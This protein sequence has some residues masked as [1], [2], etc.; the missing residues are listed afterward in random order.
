VTA[1]D[2]PLAIKEAVA[3]SLILKIPDICKLISKLLSF[4]DLAIH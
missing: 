1:G 4:T 3:S 2:L